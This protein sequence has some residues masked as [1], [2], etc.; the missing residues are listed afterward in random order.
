MAVPPGDVSSRARSMRVRSAAANSG[1]GSIGS[2]GRRSRVNGSVITAPG[3][4]VGA[5]G[6]RAGADQQRL[7]GVHGALQQGGDLRHRQVVEIAQGQGGA[8]GGGG[9]VED[10]LGQ[11]RVEAGVPRILGGRGAAVEELKAP[12]LP[13]L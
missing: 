4:L 8:V 12:F 13:L 7:G 3:A 10:L 9:A 2:I 5:G 11:E 6:G 1:S